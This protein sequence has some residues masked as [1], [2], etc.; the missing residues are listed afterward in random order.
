RPVRG[1]CVTPAP[2]P[3]RA[4]GSPLSAPPEPRAPQP[5]AG[6]PG[7]PR[8][9][10]RSPAALLARG[11]KPSR[12]CS[13]GAWLSPV[14]TL[15]GLSGV[16][17]GRAGWVPAFLS[18]GTRTGCQNHTVSIAAQ[19]PSSC[20]IF[21][22]ERFLLRLGFVVNVVGDVLAIGERRAVHV[23]GFG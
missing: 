14:R 10:H 20:A 6:S 21:S 19:S 3:D 16:R 2:W 23:D 15:W 22:G 17:S 4:R 7:P 8:P 11:A 13:A 5:P 9:L 1:P 18:L 12:G